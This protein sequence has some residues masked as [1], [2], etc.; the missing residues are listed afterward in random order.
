MRV[1]GMRFTVAVGFV[2]L[3]F[4]TT[5]C[6]QNEGWSFSYR[7]G[8]RD[9]EGHWAGG[10][11]IMHLVSHDGR[12]FAANGYWMDSH[13]EIPPDHQKQSAQVLRLDTVD[14]Q[15]QVDLE[16]G[17]ENDDALRF[18]KGNILKSVSFTQTEA[19]R[20]LSLPVRKLV[21]AAGATF[22][23]GGAVCVWVRDDNTGQW[24][25]EVV[26]HGS[27]LGGIRYVPRDIHVHRDTVTGR[28]LIFLLLGNP[29]II[30]GVYDP[31][32]NSGIRWNRTPEY[33]F[34]QAGSLRTRPL[35][36]AEA[37]GVLYFSEGGTILRRI[38]GH[39]PKYETVIDLN[40]DTD[41]DVGG[42]RGLTAIPSPDGTRESLL[43]VWAPGERSR[44]QVKRLDLSGNGVHRL[45]DERAL[46]DL[47]SERLNAR[48]TYTLGA[49]NMMYHVRRPDTREHVHLIGFQGR[50]VWNDRVKQ[51][52]HLWKNR[53]YN[54]AQFAVRDATGNYTVREVNGDWQPGHPQLVSPRAFCVSPFGKHSLFVGGHDSSNVVSDNCAWILRAPLDVALGI[55]E[56]SLIRKVPS[57]PAPEERLTNGP[58]YE[59]RVYRASEERFEHLQDRFREHT[60]QIFRRHGLTPVGY[61]IAE[62]QNKHRRT[63]A[64]L[65]KHPSR[66]Q[67]WLNWKDFNN[68]RNWQQVLKTPKYQGLLRERPESTFL[69]PEKPL[70]WPDSQSSNKAGRF[71]IVWLKT[72]EGSL[73]KT[74]QQVRDDGPAI[75]SKH[76]LRLLGTWSAFDDPESKTQ[77][78]MLLRHETPN[79]VK[80]GRVSGLPDWRQTI[81]GTAS[82]MILNSLS[83][84]PLK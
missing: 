50:P 60:D 15:W 84:S 58:L 17:R 76:G 78:V 3:A 37:N 11:E 54:G 65:L 35:G 33:P 22:P 48:V 52:T 18:M 66:Y 12:L 61:W 82:S 7:A 55:K 19:G 14:G 38:D 77:I 72:A 27:S 71:E 57:T 62:D 80:F 4:T 41:T 49:H 68:D 53:L 23:R 59:L 81:P 8:Y 46:L 39:Q 24:T 42:I 70:E 30:T 32:S 64:Y 16:L 1:E 47:M 34:P 25:Q 26:A 10:S 9:T 13:W 83:F 6:A 51:R 63:F 20:Q 31:K 43:F 56:G 2:V 69:L 28:E 74:L 40:S 5:A 36:I 45:V 75:L 44:S 21:M 73:R 29:G 79:A 67:G